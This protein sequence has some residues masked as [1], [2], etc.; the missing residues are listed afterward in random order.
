MLDSYTSDAT[1]FHRKFLVQPNK[2]Q[3]WE[4]CVGQQQSRKAVLDQ[5]SNLAP[6]G[7][8]MSVDYTDGHQ[9]PKAQA[10]SLTM[11]IPLLFWCN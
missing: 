6:S 9:T 4:R 10:D 1:A 3:G 5:D 7:N 8:Q 11:L 2:V